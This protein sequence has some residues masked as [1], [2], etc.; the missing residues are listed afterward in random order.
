METC[1]SNVCFLSTDHKSRM[2]SITVTA[3]RN[4]NTLLCLWSAS[5][6]SERDADQSPHAL[7]LSLSLCSPAVFKNAFITHLH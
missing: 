5:G 4:E 7:S 3:L 6:F 2:Q 1:P